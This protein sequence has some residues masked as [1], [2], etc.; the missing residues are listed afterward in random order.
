MASVYT[1]VDIS[2]L[3]PPNV[4]EALDF[5]AILSEMVNDL[6]GRDPSFTALIESDPAYKILEVCAYR[7][8]LIRQ[9]VNEASLAVMVAYATG[10]D[11]DQMAAR[12]DVA[13]LLITPAN[14]D[15]IPPVDAVYEDDDAFR[16]RIILSLEG[17]TTA[18]SRGSYVYHALSASGDCKDVAVT[19]LVPGTVN[20]AVLS[21]QGNGAAP[22]DTIAQVVAALNDEVVRPLC[23]TVLVEAAQVVD[24]HIE[25]VLDLFPGTGQAEIL[26]S[27]QAAAEYYSGEQHRLGRDITRSGIFA[28][29]HQPGVQNVSLLSPTSDIPIVWNQAPYCTGISLSIGGF[30][31]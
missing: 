28:A 29:L 1:K 20:V 18:G 10:A 25:A 14:L 21:R 6:R 16:Q 13:R 30:N 17:Y 7:E 3:A 11:L 19:S 27:A 22:N 9:R 31:A 12:Y 8:L 24:Y 23:D 26:S 5:E 2:Q 4:V 15:A